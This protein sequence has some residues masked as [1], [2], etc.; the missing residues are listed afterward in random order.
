MV[1]GGPDPAW[2][3]QRSTLIK[4]LY[5]AKKWKMSNPKRHNKP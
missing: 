4:M 1:T 2:R 3:E 5:K